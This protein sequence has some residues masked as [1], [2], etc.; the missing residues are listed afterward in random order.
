MKFILVVAVTALVQGGPRIQLSQ[1]G[2]FTSKASC[3]KVAQEAEATV[4]LGVTSVY[5]SYPVAIEKRCV[6]IN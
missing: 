2:E 3:E 6:A 1:L 5:G 4:R